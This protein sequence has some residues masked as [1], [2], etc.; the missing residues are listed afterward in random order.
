LATIIVSNQCGH[1]DNIFLHFPP[2]LL[3]Q[4]LK[5]PKCFCFCIHFGSRFCFNF[6]FY[7]FSPNRHI[8]AF[9]AA[10]FVHL[11]AVVICCSTAAL[12]S[13]IICFGNDSRILLHVLIRLDTRKCSPSGRGGRTSRISYFNNP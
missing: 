3:G 5:T 9:W 11:I 6:S 1:T 13:D 2:L 10:L 8:S 4:C 7:V 12:K